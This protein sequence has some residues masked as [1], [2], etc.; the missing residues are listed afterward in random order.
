MEILNKSATFNYEIIDKYDA[1]LIL[2]G[3]EVK[4]IKN[5]QMSLKGS[6]I[7]IKNTPTPEIYLIKSSVSLYKKAGPMPSYDPER[8]RKLL[9]TRQEIN[10]LL[11]KLK[12][13]GLTLIPLR[14]YNKRNLIKLEFALVSPKKKFDKKESIKN[15]EIDRQIQRALKN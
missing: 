14:V 13:K 1:G 5:G 2:F 6:Y 4:A 8:P 9:L 3:H 7:A 10:K 15:R 11:A 12:Q